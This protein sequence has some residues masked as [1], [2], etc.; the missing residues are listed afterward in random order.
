MTTWNSRSLTFS[1]FKYCQGLNYDVLALT[2]LW[3]RA[4]EFSKHCK[5][6]LSWTYGQAAID[7]NTGNEVFPEDPA[8]GVGILL[9]P[10]AT[11]KYMMH[12]SPCKRICWVRLKG[13]TTNLFIIAIYVPHKARVKPAQSDTLHTL[14]ELLKTVPKNDCVILLGDFNAQFG[15][16][17]QKCTG[18]WTSGPSSDNAEPILDIARM[19]NLFAVN[20]KFQPAK[21]KSVATYLACTQGSDHSCMY[22]GRQV[23][24]VYH[25]RRY[26]GI[27]TGF[28]CQDGKRKWTIRFEY[29]YVLQCNEKT[30]KPLL[31]PFPKGRRS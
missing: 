14:T 24:T 15:S 16:L 5:N 26:D 9:S 18:K 27:V 7:P 17:I 10:R 30:L 4:S 29:D 19:F 11:E 23:C 13:P 6:P 8:A 20:T 25:G 21:R 3:S 28:S 2:E 22:H 31:K 1:R 12:G